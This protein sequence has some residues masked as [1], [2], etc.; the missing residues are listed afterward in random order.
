MASQV[1]ATYGTS[2]KTEYRASQ[3]AAINIAKRQYQKEYMEYWNSTIAMT[4]TGR[5]VEAVIAPCAPFAAARPNLYAYYG[6]S[7][8]F[9]TA[10]MNLNVSRQ[11]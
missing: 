1:S 10:Q 2:P 11:V 6:K 5:P 9:Q 7:S 8:S 3:I 4:G